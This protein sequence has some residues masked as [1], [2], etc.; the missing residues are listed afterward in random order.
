VSGA[1][2]IAPP[3]FVLANGPAFCS[4]RVRPKTTPVRPMTFMKKLS[5]CFR[6]RLA[7]ALL[8]ELA[9]AAPGLRAATVVHNLTAAGQSAAHAFTTGASAFALES[10][11]VRM[12][13]SVN[14]S[15][16]LKLW[17]GSGGVPTTLV[18]DL[19]AMTVGGATAFN[20][21]RTSTNKPVLAPNIRYWVSVHQVSGSLNWLISN[22]TNTTALGPMLDNQ[23]FSNN[24]G[25]SWSGYTQADSH[26]PTRML[27]LVTPPSFEKF[28]AEIAQPVP[29][30]DS[31]PVPVTPA[32][33][34]KLLAVAPSYGIEIL[35]PPH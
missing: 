3:A 9:F 23:A 13:A 7:L 16:R 2:G 18:E 30:F 6:L 12:T 32:D 22:S 35:P 14:G 17:S 1:R 33:I 5:A 29:S 11:F 27:I 8:A 26:M 4:T 19:G 28:M 10:I 25:A 31:P 15:V 21:S 34:E 24:D 20:Y